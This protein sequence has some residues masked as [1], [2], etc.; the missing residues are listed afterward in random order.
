MSISKKL[1]LI[2]E[3]ERRNNERWAKWGEQMAK[4]AHEKPESE[5]RSEGEKGNTG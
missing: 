4:T 5:R 3:M 2:G 1:Y